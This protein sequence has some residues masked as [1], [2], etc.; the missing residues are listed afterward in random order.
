MGEWQEMAEN[1]CVRTVY[2]GLLYKN[3]G[4]ELRVQLS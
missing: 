4:P 1:G 2:A 3:L